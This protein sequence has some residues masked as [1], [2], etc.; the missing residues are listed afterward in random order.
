MLTDFLALGTAAWAVAR[1]R[2]VHQDT[3]ASFNAAGRRE[4]GVGSGGSGRSQAH[5]S[6]AI[7]NFE[8]G[9]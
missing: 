1:L 3:G 4:S 6:P 7:R 2:P 5:C 9:G 8:T